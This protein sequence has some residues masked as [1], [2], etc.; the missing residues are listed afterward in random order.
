M[1]FVAL[2]LRPWQL[3]MISM[4]AIPRTLADDLLLMAK[5]SRALHLFSRA[6]DATM[7]HLQ[8]LGG[9][10]APSKSKIF[11]TISDHRQWL[12][13]YLWPAIHETISVVHHMRD[14]GASLSTTFVSNTSI[15]RDRLRKAIGGLKRIRHLPFAMRQKSSSF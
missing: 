14:L 12:A 8:D 13:A 1:V 6:F 15:S 5:G 2:L 9:R 4:G 11:A 10:I 7:V 3:Q